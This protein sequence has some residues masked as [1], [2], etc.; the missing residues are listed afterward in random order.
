MNLILK[1]YFL[2]VPGKYIV[3]IQFSQGWHIS[4][5]RN[6]I[7]KIMLCYNNNYIQCIMYNTCLKLLKD[8]LCKIMIAK[9]LSFFKQ[10]NMIN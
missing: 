3:I 10:L 7:N 2:Q 1:V 5:V 4:D 6:Y 9:I 8:D